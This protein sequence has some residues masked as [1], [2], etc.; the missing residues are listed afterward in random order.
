M[1]SFTV[2]KNK[3][4]FQCMQYFSA[5]ITQKRTSWGFYWVSNR[6]TQ[7]LLCQTLLEE[8]R[9]ALTVRQAEHM[10]FLSWL[11]QR[12]KE[13][14]YV[15]NIP[16]DADF[17]QPGEISPR[18]V[19][20]VEELCCQLLAIPGCWIQWMNSLW[21]WGC[22][23]GNWSVQLEQTQEFQRHAQML[24]LELN[25]FQWCCFHIKTNHN[26]L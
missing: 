7:L 24:C 22:L 19:A 20:E 26:S 8:E 4:I 9:P 15:P 2:N 21:A 12:R 25:C 11:L 1:I 17:C 5:V 3:Y 6:E 14:K 23:Q 16:S 10:N 13:N 18:L